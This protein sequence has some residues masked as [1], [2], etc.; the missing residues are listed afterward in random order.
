MATVLRWGHF[1]HCSFRLVTPAFCWCVTY[2]GKLRLHWSN[3]TITEKGKAMSLTLTQL[4]QIWNSTAPGTWPSPGGIPGDWAE[5]R[6]TWPG[7]GSFCCW[8]Q[9]SFCS[10]LVTTSDVTVLQAPGCADSQAKLSM[11]ILGWQE[12]ETK[13]TSQVRMADVQGCYLGCYIHTILKCWLVRTIMLPT[14]N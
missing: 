12:V 6:V 4:K 13:D 10:P 7:I 14:C 1:P 3:W 9:S 8:W 5:R 2:I 11:N